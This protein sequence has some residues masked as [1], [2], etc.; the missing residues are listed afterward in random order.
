M[1]WSKIKTI[2]ILA[3]LALDIYLIYE[4]TGL[5]ESQNYSL[6]EEIPVENTL[7]SYGVTYPQNSSRDIQKDQYLSAKSKTFSQEEVKKWEKGL[8][9]GQ[10]IRIVGS[11]ILQ[12]ELEKPLSLSDS[13]KQEDLTDFIQTHILNGDQ[14]R[15]WNKTDNIITYYQQY[16]GKIL[17]QNANAKLTLI[18]NEQNK[19]VSYRQTYLDNI[20]EIEDKEAIIRPVNAVY[21]LFMNSYINNDSEVKKF[22][23]GYYSPQYASTMQ[24][25]ST[26]VLTPTWRIVMDDGGSLFVNAFDNQIIKI[27][28]DPSKLE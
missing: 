19:V 13:F 25:S 16:D 4:Y 21:T 26:Q 8:L 24:Y 22:E 18:L 17:Y 14:Y 23:L 11:N 9:K 1:D 12:A 28:S 10:T 20:K 15:Y 5:K 27:D 7:A 2:F 3:F 6:E